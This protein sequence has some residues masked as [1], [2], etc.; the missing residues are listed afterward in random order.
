M[1]KSKIE[2][3]RGGK[4][5]MLDNIYIF[6]L[7]FLSLGLAYG[8]L[9]MNMGNTTTTAFIIRV[10]LPVCGF[11]FLIVNVCL[12]SNLEQI[13]YYGG[14]MGIVTIVIFAFYSLFESVDLNKKG[15]R[16]E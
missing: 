15:K 8:G 14:L 9:I 3:K 2:H 6:I 16:C 13:G 5:R 7:A 10:V 1:D 4:A 12:G 11:V